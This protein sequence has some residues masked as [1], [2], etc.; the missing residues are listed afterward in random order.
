MV[1][2]SNYLSQHL[3]GVEF[4]GMF[5]N[6]FLCGLLIHGQCFKWDSLMEHSKPAVKIKQPN[7]Y[8]LSQTWCI[9]HDMTCVPFCNQAWRWNITLSVQWFSLSRLPC[10]GGFQPVMSDCQRAHSIIHV[11]NGERNKIDIGIGHR[12]Q[13]TGRVEIRR[14]PTL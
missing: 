2:I 12:H 4:I 3:C 14:I 8:K 10:I 1:L 9:K 7:T 5:S 11:P 6:R 13:P